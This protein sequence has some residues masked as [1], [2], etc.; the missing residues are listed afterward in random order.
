VNNAHPKFMPHPTA[1]YVV[2]WGVFLYLFIT[3]LNFSTNNSP[4]LVSGIYFV[5]FGIHELAHLVLSFLPQIFV[6]A[7]GSISEIIFA[8][9]LLYVALKE[10]S[11]F[12]AAFS[13]L[14]V[15]FSFI[16]AGRYMADARAQVLPLIGPGE[17]VNHD[18]HYVFSQLGWLNYD[19][20]IGGSMRMLGITIGL[21]SLAFGLSLIIAK[22]AHAKTSKVQV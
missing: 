1:F 2:G 16:S 3:I 12:A 15:M 18:W 5:N 21:A 8:L 14:W 6:A 7:A 20:L 13:G 11:Y 22:I 17:T 4:L 10:K 19:T 9:T